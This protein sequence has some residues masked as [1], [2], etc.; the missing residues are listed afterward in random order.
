MPRLNGSATTCAPCS[1]ARAAVASCDAS[2]ITTT[3]KLGS[4]ARI[5]SITWPIAPSSLN[6]GT[7]A[8]LFMRGTPTSDERRAPAA[9]GGDR[10]ARRARV[11]ARGGRAPRPA[12]DRRAASRY[13]ATASSALVDDE[14]LR[15]GLE[16]P[17]DAVVRVRDDRR[18]GGRE[19]ERPARRRRVDRRVRAARDA[20]VDARRGD[21]AREDVERDVA[22]EPRRADVA[23]EVAAAEC[24]VDV[25]Q[26]ARR[27]ADHRLHPVAPE[28]VAVAVEEDVHLL[29]DRLRREELGVGAPEDRLGAARTELAQ[30][31]E[32][33]FGVRDQRG[34]TR[35][36]RRRG[37]S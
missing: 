32:P 29:L 31:L 9:R 24:E 27:L 33:A 34:R 10:C 5:S 36:G 21:R 2:S 13:A 11:R 6:A 28:L 37:T 26:R 8:I 7:I 15:P 18:A 4:N 1:R 12:P 23:V 30:P 25:G 22:D 3:S 35:T 20:E 17:L 16:P 14:Q 19:L